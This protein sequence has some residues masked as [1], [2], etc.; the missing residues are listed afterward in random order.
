MKILV[1][2]GMFLFALSFCNITE[3]FTGTKDFKP[4]DEAQPSA[5]SEDPTKPDGQEDGKVEKAKLTAEQDK[6]LTGDTLKW[7]EQG[8]SWRLPKGWRKPGPIL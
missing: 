1:S 4:A 5:N 7:E 8:L 6:L 2:I 3:R